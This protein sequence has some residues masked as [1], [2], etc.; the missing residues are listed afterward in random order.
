[1]P[2]KVLIGL[3]LALIATLV[4]IPTASS[5]A[6]PRQ[7]QTVLHGVV[8]SVTGASLLVRTPEGRTVFVNL[9]G[10]STEAVPF[11]AVGHRVAVLGHYGESDTVF[12]AQDIQR[13][14]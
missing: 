5:I 10:L 1:V 4:A 9:A 3:V 14:G 11:L 12:I 6:Q 8:V 7:D 13:T 2:K